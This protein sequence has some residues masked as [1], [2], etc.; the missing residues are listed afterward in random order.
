MIK[1]YFKTAWRNLVKNKA[2]SFINVGGLSVG[3]AVAIIITLWATD[4][5]SYDKFH[6]GLPNIYMVM[7]NEHQD[8]EIATYQASPG[9]L[10]GAMRNEM[11][12]ITFAARVSFAG[13]QLI[14]TGDKSIYEN[15]IYAEPEYFKIM[16][17][18]AVAGNPEAAL[19]ETGSVVI[20]ESAAK[21]LFGKEDPLGKMITHN[22]LRNLKVGAVI[23]DV[24]TNSSFKFD[25]VLPFTIYEK[26]NSGGINKW[27]NNSL[28]TWVQL[29]PGANL[30]GLNKKLSK[31][32]QDKKNDST[33]ELFAYPLSQLAMHGKFKNGKP[34]GGRIEMIMMLTILGMFVLLIAC[35]NF[36]NL[37]TARSEGRSREVGVRKSLGATKKNLIFQFLSE[38]LLMVFLA[39][40]LGVI[41]AKLLVPGFNE[42]TDKNISFDIFNFKSW[43]VLIAAGIIT[44]LL[45]GSYPAFFLSR[46]QPV[47]VLKGVLSQHKGG[48]LLRRG[49]VTFQF[50]ISIFLIIVTIVVYKQV[51]HAQQRPIGYNQENLIDIP[52]R[53]DMT[54]KFAILKTE[55]LQIPGVKSVSAGTDDLVNFGSTVTGFEWPGKTAAQDFPFCVTR[56]QYDWTKTTGLKVAEGRDFS[57][58]YGDDT[59]ACLINM[60]AVKKMR[61]KGSAIGTMVDNHRIIGVI[62]DFIYNDAFTSPAPLIAYLGKGSMNHFFVRLQPGEKWQNDMAAIEKAVK[63]TN[64]NFPF[65]F[66]LTEEQY[67]RKFRGIQSGGQFASFVGILAIIIS[68]LGLFAL[69]AFVAER[70]TKEIGIRKVLGASVEGIW[71]AL[72]KDFLKPVFLAIVIASPLAAWAMQQMLL[73]MEYHIQLSWWMFA[74]AGLIAVLI[75]VVT[76]S[77]QGVKAAM[78]NPVNS[79]RTE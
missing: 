68:C 24:P 49:L 9:P 60:A 6:A 66:R 14:K 33:V 46:F 47:K 35:I 10:A 23:K 18:P 58:G 17:F 28:L 8:G 29:K 75:A 43:L 5:Y 36:M 56:V 40:G 11:P 52:A 38:A 71:F 76:V 57:A 67:Q 51:E 54:D 61:L 37:S 42:L 1:S 20:T 13:Q 73:S 77:F 39:L 25:I 72:S 32:L 62:A 12:E 44:G 64:P 16:S 4:E 53:G 55:L 41:I 15:G 21:K 69:S 74:L 19:H 31:L 50:V 78:A 30:T 27:D 26:E 34:S 79:L 7:Q 22:N 65:E 48:S 2:T 3:L 45:A 63:K 70:R 59:S